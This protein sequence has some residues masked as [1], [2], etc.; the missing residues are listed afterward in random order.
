MESK[1]QHAFHSL[2][3]A[4]QTANENDRT[5]DAH[6]FQPWNHVDYLQRLGTFRISTWFSKAASWSAPE[7]SRRGWCNV[8]KDKLQCSL[9]DATL[10]HKPDSASSLLSTGHRPLCAWQSATCPTSFVRPRLLTG[11]PGVLALERAASGIASL[12]L[13]SC[14]SRSRVL[15]EG[16][17]IHVV[18]SP[19]AVQLMH[20]AALAAAQTAQL[21][22]SQAS[23]LST[24]A[25]YILASVL[26]SPSTG[27]GAASLALA[28][29]G[30][31]ALGAPMETTVRHT[32]ALVMPAVISRSPALQDSDSTVHH[33][34]NAADVARSGS[35]LKR[36]RSTG[37][38]SSSFTGAPSLQ[39]SVCGAITTV[40]AL[41]GRCVSAASARTG[42][43]GLPVQRRGLHAAAQSAVDA[44]ER[45]S[46]AFQATDAKFGGSGDA[47][48]SSDL[49]SSD[50]D[51]QSRHKL[52]SLSRL[53]GYG[54]N[55]GE[56]G[57]DPVQGHKWHCSAARASYAL[58]LATIQALSSASTT[59]S[60][61]PASLPG[62]S[63]LQVPTLSIR[64][65]S[66]AAAPN[67]GLGSNEKGSTNQ[68]AAITS[69]DVDGDRVAAALVAVST[70]TLGVTD[71]KLVSSILRSQSR[72][73]AHAGGAN[74]SA[75]I[76]SATAPTSTPGSTH[77][78]AKRRQSLKD[79]LSAYDF[80]Y[81]GDDEAD[82]PQVAEDAEGQRSQPIL[83]PGWLLYTLT[84]YEAVN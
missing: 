41:I 17:R 38:L 67:V 45:A 55:S 3:A 2:T 36:K 29:C 46:A 34:G 1:L 24:A 72:Q 68:P 61:G 54:T 20:A 32:T 9:C 26:C 5:G 57:I 53:S 30:W 58:P 78:D 18:V 56:S 44:A 16:E 74:G 7:C 40:D 33:G 35:G 81:P 83:I 82:V 76:A 51:S 75:R 25:E 13:E 84:L 63:G 21:P 31:R 52:A 4:V 69:A 43:D 6:H 49:V 65:S 14:A 12:L 39:C 48:H 60:S 27:L 73:A 28:L 42:V 80:H 11:R 66:A 77:S 10:E 8:G 59:L 23:F 15:E 62:G 64:P 47:G 50:M 37:D 70:A 79:I 22:E 71:M 19:T